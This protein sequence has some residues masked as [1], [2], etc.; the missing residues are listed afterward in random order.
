MKEVAMG[1]FIS[2][3]IVFAVSVLNA[4]S[5]VLPKDRLVFAQQL[6]SRGLYADAL[7]EYL[8][9]KGNKVVAQD[10]VLFRLGD[11][12]K[13][14]GEK[15][16][17]E[18]CYSELLA[19]SPQSQYADYARLNRAML[20][21]GERRIADLKALDRDGVSPKIRA[22]VLYC[23]GEIAEASK[24]EKSAM[25]FYSRVADIGGTNNVANL[26]LF[27]KCAIWSRSKNAQD[28]RMAL[29]T[30]LN[31]AMS[32][33]VR[34]AEEALFF[35]G[36]IS[37]GE[38]R[39][40][41][42]AMLFRR[43]AARF[44]G[45]KRIGQARPF[46]AWSEYLSGNYQEALT[47]A[48]FLRDDGNEDGAYVA[49]AS[50]RMLGRLDDAVEA[51]GFA[52][53]KFPDGKYAD[54]EWFERLTIY[55]VQKKNAEVLKELA[56]KTSPSDEVK[57]RA[58]NIGCEAAIAVTNM[59]LAVEYA[60]RTASLEKSPL[61]PNASH[62]LAWL[63]EQLGDYASSASEYRSLADKWPENK[64][65]P[66]A[67]FQAGV[68]ETKAGNPDQARANWTRLLERYPDS[69]LAAEALFYRAMEE[70]KKKE[71]RAASSSLNELL[72]RFPETPKK[73][74]AY[75]WL[76]MSAKS[77]DD[78]PDAEKN[79]RLAL[80][81][82]PTPEFA[83][84]IKLEL[85]FI[86]KSRGED[87]EAATVFSELID[88]KAV[89]RLTPG[90][91]AWTSEALLAVSNYTASLKAAEILEKRNADP[92]WNQ[93]G[94]YL[95]G[96]AEYSLGHKDAAIAA[97][98][99][100]LASGARTASGAMAALRLGQ[101]QTSLG[102]FPEAQKNLSDAVSRSDST[103]LI[104]VRVKAYAALA[105]NEETRGDADAALKYHLV[106]G[107]LFDDPE[108][109]PK[110]ILAASQILRAQGKLEEAAKLLDELKTRYPDAVKG[111][112][113]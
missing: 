18:K 23:L 84:E 93:I 50:L 52:L 108:L 32:K 72:K 65:A 67:L 89:D 75:Y 31:L 106:V 73:S 83:R 76:A 59:P 14:L 5:E 88:T 6:S 9:L 101:A 43:L 68:N 20:T 104:G 82:S 111:E 81:Q 92:T 99:R 25:D 7:N 60:K 37:Y 63:H 22:T 109:V 74:E 107:T 3:F 30:Y 61:A 45:S 86:L 49:A 94:A 11:T 69:P 36:M 2:I 44:E 113:K 42:A 79:F 12:Y 39:W 33:D 10:E 85:A 13:A 87:R 90:R 100:S 66:Q 80:Q 46:A 16:E 26:A 110:S 70:V 78:I 40:R 91:L 95:T 96:C 8:A 47:H 1:K 4:A 56:A 98:E 27:R 64:I 57:D 29:G 17:A 58:W 19:A 103:E 21:D 112:D 77:I 53:S 24:D 102:K 38:N 41:E 48:V 105:V 54:R 55:S 34:I 51:Y 35:A 15:R 28:R 62:R 71:F 97:W